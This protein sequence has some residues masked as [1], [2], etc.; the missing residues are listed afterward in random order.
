[1]LVPLLLAFLQ[2]AEPEKA[3]APFGPLEV[4]IAADVLGLSFTEKE[5]ELMLPDVLERLREFEKL[6]AVPLANH[7]QPALL[8]APLP[9]AM[10]A[11]EREALEQPAAAGP[12]PERPA[13][14][15]DLA[16]ESIWTLNQLVT[17]KVVSCEELTRMF[18]ARLKRLDA[19][20]HCVVTP[21]DERAMAQ[22]R[23]LDAEVAAGAAGSRGPLHGI[24]WVAKDLL[25]V[26]G[27]PTT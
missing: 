14:L 25:A 12:P 11:S 1:M 4:G 16:Y 9:A 15:E 5:L 23:K 3:S 6:R 21:L 22:A 13:N 19:T 7:V 10:R 26:K 2:E 17:R 8:F 20:L 24:P 18:L 27:T